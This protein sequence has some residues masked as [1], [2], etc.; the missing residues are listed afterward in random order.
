MENLLKVKTS[1]NRRPIFTLKTNK[2]LVCLLDTGADL[3]VFTRGKERLLQNFPEA[4][5]VKDV[6]A[7]ISGFGKGVDIV[8]VY[9]VPEIIFQD[10][11]DAN[12]SIGFKNVI[13]AC[14][15][16]DLKVQLILGAP[17]FCKIN[18][19]IVN[20]D[21]AGKQIWFEYNRDEQFVVPVLSEK[22]NSMLESISVFTDSNS[23]G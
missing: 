5:L 10:S 3:C 14:C 12:I 4:T 15:E 18:Y 1:D 11:W 2:R 19:K 23:S 22:D 6:K 21:I 9:K 7:A 13:I 17:L 20:E 16:K 8:D